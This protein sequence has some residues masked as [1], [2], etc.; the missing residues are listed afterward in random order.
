MLGDHQVLLG[1]PRGRQHS[2]QHTGRVPNGQV[3]RSGVNVVEP[4]SITSEV[5]I[6]CDSA[7]G[8]VGSIAVLQTW[9]GRARE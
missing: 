5:N 2:Q 3:D 8:T 9:H 7:P 4:L 1:D 6:G